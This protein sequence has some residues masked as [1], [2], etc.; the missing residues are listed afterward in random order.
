VLYLSPEQV[1]GTAPRPASDVFSLASVV[2]YAVRGSGPFD[3]TDT[4]P[5]TV[6]R[7][8]LGAPPDLRGVGLDLTEILAPCFEKLTEHRC[9]ADSLV[10]RLIRTEIADAPWPTMHHDLWMRNFSI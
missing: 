4:S 5:L 3:G 1:L 10:D 2:V 9:S 8:I 7:R 6:A